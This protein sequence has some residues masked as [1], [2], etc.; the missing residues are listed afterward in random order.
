MP[1]PFTCV[2]AAAAATVGGY[3][4]DATSELGKTLASGW[5]GN[6]FHL[7]TRDRANRII[8]ALSGRFRDGRIPE[9]HE[10]QRAA[11]ESLRQAMTALAL[12]IL[13]DLDPKPGIAEAIRKQLSLGDDPLDALLTDVRRNAEREW[14]AELSRLLKSKHFQ[15]DKELLIAAEADPAGL[16]ASTVDSDTASQLHAAVIQWIDAKLASFR[17]RPDCVDKFIDEGWPIPPDHSTRIT[18]YQAWCVFF[19]ESIKDN[20]R[21]FKVFIAD[22]VAELKTS[23]GELANFGQPTFDQY[24]AWLDQ[25]LDKV[26]GALLELDRK[27]DSILARQDGHT[28]AL[29][30]I[31]ENVRHLPAAVSEIVRSMAEPPSR[32]AAWHQLP[33]LPEHF[34]G[35]EREVEGICNALIRAAADATGAGLTQV[36]EGAG[37]LGKSA[38]AI[39]IGHKLSGQ[40]P[41]LQFFLRMRTHSGNP[42]SA[43]AARDQLLQ[44][45]YPAWN[46]PQ[47]ESQRWTAYHSLFMQPDRTPR[48]GMLIIDDCAGDAQLRALAPTARIPVIV[49]SRRALAAGTPVGI[50]R[51]PRESAVSLL[52]S[53]CPALA[54]CGDHRVAAEL[55]D[56]CGCFPIALRAAGGYLK[57]TRRKG[58]ALRE[59][60]DELRS[61]PLRRLHDDDPDVNPRRVLDH[62]YR[63][64]TEQEAS[65]LRAITVFVAD[66][67][68]HAAR[69]VGQ[70]TGDTI[71]R[72]TELHLIEFDPD[73]ER[74]KWHD[75]MRAVVSEKLEPDEREAAGLRYVRYVV[76]LLERD[77]APFVTGQGDFDEGLRIADAE[78]LHVE[79][80]INWLLANPR[81][82]HELCT[83]GSH[84]GNTSFRYRLSFGVQNDLY[85]AALVAA[86]C[87][88]DR[89]GEANA[90]SGLGDVAYMLGDNVTARQHY[91]AAREIHLQTGDRSGEANALFGLGDVAR[92]LGDKVTARQHYEAAREIHLQ[93]GNRGGEANALFGLGDVA[94]MLG[95]RVTA[96]QH[97]EAA[98]EIHLQTG[99]RSG[100][101]NALLGLG[102]VAYMLGDNV[103]AR[104][105][106]EAAREIHLQT[107]DR[108]GEANA[109]LGL[110]DVARMLGDNGTARQ[111]FEAAREIHLQTGNRGGEANALFGLG[112]VAR[113]LGDNGTARQHFEAAREIHLQTG[114]RSGEANAL[115]GLGNV[116]RMLGDNGTARQHFEA[117]REIH[118]QT[119]DRSGE[120][121]A[122]S[123][124]GNVAYML[125]DNVT[126]RQHYEAAREIHLQTGDRSGEANALSGLG[127]VAYMLGD[128]VTARQHYEAAREIHLQTGDRSGE[129]NALSGLGN[130]AYMLGDNVT[131]RQHYEAA[132]EIH[133][134]TGNRGGE[135][136]ALSGLGNVAYMLGDNVTARQHYE[137]AREI[138]LQTGNRG[139]EA[140]ALFG[141]GDVARMLGDKVTARQHFEAAREIFV[142]LGDDKGEAWVA[143]RIARLP[144]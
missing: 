137:A 27:A 126:A 129:A 124:L 139:G 78:R 3:L 88:G 16:L 23:V 17:G 25:R 109:L 101:A 125:G 86:R 75:L 11:V 108:S 66:F 94:G 1:D 26:A 35:R 9:N 136:N 38:L 120:A 103:T 115:S 116:A 18:L 45:L 2:C 79:A 85:R 100:E 127:N 84:L 60:L 53:L 22:T 135:A 141:L 59:Y 44:Q 14:M 123:G 56:L 62:S 96:R 76:S 41:D 89:S 104:Q 97:F 63:A 132:R 112:D 40:Y 69:T 5:L 122:L 111:H 93:T 131:A 114:D 87:I 33:P 12:G 142:E 77:A 57:R 107:G 110:G 28:R 39:A 92:M 138:H 134:Q 73:R 99:D 81:H 10:L 119:G 43:E 36:I 98:R 67:D 80:S 47:D 29:G 61:N 42:V 34:V 52:I 140:N 65:A 24:R 4:T 72:L 118:L 49:T 51:L 13:N 30:E 19:R 83:L 102:N 50:A 128:N 71:D 95:D 130:V 82:Q 144:P 74:H 90:L 106:F 37:G 21:V 46:L 20:D 54:D 55:A 70:C 68:R 15:V 121:N 64:L 113:M 58:A 143:E 31:A 8:H 117:A 48:R 7:R 91:E 105:H 32:S 133:L 6:E